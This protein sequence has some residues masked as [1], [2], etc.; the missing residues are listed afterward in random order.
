MHLRLDEYHSSLSPLLLVT[1]E[2]GAVRALDFADHESRMRRLLRDHYGEYELNR[3]AAPKSVVRALDKYFD[4][5]FTALDGVRTATGGTP[6]QRA[7][8][9]AL[10]KI[11]PGNTKNYGEIAAELGNP[12][13]SRAVGAANGANP[14]A[15]V[16]PCHRVIGADGSLS[17]YGGG[18]PR[19]RW[20][21]EHE[22][23]DTRAA[24]GRARVLAVSGPRRAQ[25]SHAW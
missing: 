15:I 8:W 12:K 19:K 13:A 1:D 23:A 25:I 6:F 18:V 16:V 22:R 20:L 4:G 14:I 5:E 9:R 21:L 3:R 17:G 24:M 11:A 2:E 7:V 10:R